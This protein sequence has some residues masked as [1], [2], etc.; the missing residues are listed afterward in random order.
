MSWAIFTRRRR[1]ATLR[2]TLLVTALL[3]V[4]IAAAVMVGSVALAMSWIE[5]GNSKAVNQ[6]SPNTWAWEASIRSMRSDGTGTGT[7]SRRRH[8]FTQRAPLTSRAR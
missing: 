4:S 8:V 5:V 2:S 7:S 1:W 3:V 6:T